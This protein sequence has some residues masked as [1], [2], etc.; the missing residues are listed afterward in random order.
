MITP[1]DF[2][3]HSPRFL[4]QNLERNI[5]LIEPLR[6]IAAAK[7]ATVA[8]VAIAW[9][10]SRGSD[11]VPLI[12]AHR[13]TSL[14]ESLAAL[15]MTLSSRELQTLEEACLKMSPPAPVTQKH[16]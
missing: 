4:G 5:R 1:N 8:Q 12:G 3:N 9:V 2:R 11:I 15:E 6:R 13:R 10:L 14:I 16:K 7:R